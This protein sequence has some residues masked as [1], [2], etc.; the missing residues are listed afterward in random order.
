M[1]RLNEMFITVNKRTLRSQ[2]YIILCFR[3]VKTKTMFNVVVNNYS[4]KD[5]QSESEV[6]KA[7]QIFNES[8]K[9]VEEIT[10]YETDEREKQVR[11]KRF[12]HN[13]MLTK[14]RE[15]LKKDFKNAI[16]T[17]NTEMWRYFFEG[18]ADTYLRQYRRLDDEGHDCMET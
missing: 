1:S 17:M 18:H 2:K 3:E 12:I 5:F 7:V 6:R 4:I 16:C 10:Q 14:L 15:V 8:E 13:A 11:M 9:Y